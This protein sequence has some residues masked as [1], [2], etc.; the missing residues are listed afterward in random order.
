MRSSLLTRITKNSIVGLLEKLIEIST[1]M[2]SIAILARYLDIETF[3]LYT[4]I[5]TFAGM[6][7]ILCS[8]GLDRIIV[9]DIAA[10]RENFL[11]YIQSIKGARIILAGIS[12]SLMIIISFPLG[13]NNKL[14][15]C[16]LF[17]FAISEVISMYSTIYMSVFKAFEKMEYNTIITSITKILALSG[18]I[19][20]AYFNLGFLGIFVSM[21]IGNIGK[22]FVTAYI[23][24][25]YYSR[26]LIPVSF[27]HSKVIVKDSLIIAAS[28][29]FA[30]ASI[31]M[32]VFLLKAFGTLK[33]V[34]YFQAANVLFIQL[35]P[36]A[37]VIVAA[38]Y[39]AI[40]SRKYD[41]NVILENA[42]K[43][44]FMLSLPL[45]ALT[46]FYGDD[47]I[48]L[49]Y[50]SKYMDAVPAMKI[51]ILSLA[52]TFLVHL[53]EIGLLVEYRQDLLTIGWG[54]AFLVNIVLGIVIVP[55][56]GLIGCAT[57]M[58]LSYTALFFA[59]YLFMM[60]NTIF[61]IKS[62]IFTKPITAFIVMS[63]YLYFIS[64]IDKPFNIIVDIINMV[65]S[66]VLYMLVLFFFKAF[67]ITD[68][69]YLIKT[70]LPKN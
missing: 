34:A 55:R 58:S 31:R 56:F 37:S 60:K 68:I 69:K 47:L 43:Y 46:F 42:A 44:I 39:P 29:F 8:V 57:V 49:V 15:L 40:A 32:G 35:Q 20:V 14:A 12:L 16:A 51:L 38:L 7:L 10:N 23:F 61:K 5:V 28:T 30:L 22:A 27:T 70:Y 11:A 41:S 50:G 6:L 26:N 4:L 67:S 21:A 1:G 3:G 59:L 63:F 2:A 66:I 18:L 17:I 54:I 24:K 36:A 19:I 45:M 33:E 48:M 64:T 53:F 13:L 9:R 65:V 52:F 25:R 62:N